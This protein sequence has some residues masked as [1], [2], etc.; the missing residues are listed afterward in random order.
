MSVEQAIVEFLVQGEGAVTAATDKIGAD[1]TSLEGAAKQ[2]SEAVKQSARDFAQLQSSV[3]STLGKM[4]IAVSLAEKLAHASGAE[5][6]GEA[7]R[8]L[9]IFGEGISG[10]LGGA[11]LGASFGPWGLAIGALGGAAVGGISS[12][13]DFNRQAE[14]REKHLAEAAAKRAVEIARRHDT[15]DLPEEI[16]RQAAAAWLGG[17]IYHK[18][19]RNQ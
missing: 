11:R 16:Q 19:P 13:V 5:K 4:R 3:T 12:A 7:D 17:S 14:E 9:G 8:V 15:S 10:A 18:P 2:T 6:G 1:L